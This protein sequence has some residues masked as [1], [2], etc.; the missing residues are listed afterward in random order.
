MF[1]HNH[2]IWYMYI[3]QESV[4]ILL[5]YVIVRHYM[6]KC[7]VNEIPSRWPYLHNIFHNANSIQKIGFTKESSQQILLSTAWLILKLWICGWRIRGCLNNWLNMEFIKICFPCFRRKKFVHMLHSHFAK[8]QMYF[9]MLPSV[10]DLS[11][12]SMSSMR[13]SDTYNLIVAGLKLIM[14]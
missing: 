7:H 14:V 13:G 9:Y 2:I 3:L 4:C 5:T 6:R 11:T 10:G 1:V 12:Y 8:N